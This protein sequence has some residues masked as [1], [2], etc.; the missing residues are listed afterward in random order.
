MKHLKK[1]NEKFFGGDAQA[2]E[3]DIA[4]LEK[5]TN[6]SQDDINKVSNIVDEISQVSKR[7]KM[8]GGVKDHT[9]PKVIGLIDII[10]KNK[11]LIKKLISE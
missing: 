9:R 7:V 2:D 6:L 5:D 11:E 8:F 1:F 10:N 4:S 3:I